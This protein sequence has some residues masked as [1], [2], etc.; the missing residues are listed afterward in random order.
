MAGDETADDAESE[1]ASEPVSSTVLADLF[2]CSV[3]EIEA[4]ARDDLV[5]RTRRGRY[6]L[7]Q[8][9]RKYVR[10][11]RK[12]A[13]GYTSSDGSVDAVKANVAKRS[14]ETQILQVKYDREI[15]KLIEIDA[16]RHLWAGLV[17]TL[18]QFVRG[19][20][21]KIVFLIPHLSND[22]M[23]AIRKLVDDGLTDVAL[24][25]GYDLAPASAEEPDELEDGAATE[26][27]EAAA[28]EPTDPVVKPDEPELGDADQSTERR[29]RPSQLEEVDELAEE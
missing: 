21:T 2:D 6:D 28:A 27:T 16:A 19:L 9:T 20:P 5:V 23:R 13:A 26:T 18:R 24:D 1:K 7:R 3:K 15:G 29:A 8:S 4:F 12:V 17:R 25:R 22:D 10:H 11:L 14:I